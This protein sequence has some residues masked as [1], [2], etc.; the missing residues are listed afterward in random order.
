MD[1]DELMKLVE[2]D[3]VLSKKVIISAQPEYLVLGRRGTGT[4]NSRKLGLG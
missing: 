3:K 1:F 2:E 4:R